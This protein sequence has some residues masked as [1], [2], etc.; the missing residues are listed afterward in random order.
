MRNILWAF[1]L[2]PLPAWA[3]DP[4]AIH[5]NVETSAL[6]VSECM[7]D[8]GGRS[9]R[10]QPFFKCRIENTT[11]NAISAAS[12]GV[13]I[14]EPER[15][16]QWM[17]EDEYPRHIGRREIQGGMEPGEVITVLL[18]VRQFPDRA[19]PSKVEITAHFTEAY[20]AD[21]ALIE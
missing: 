2:A 20:D 5:I 8:T 21:G 7:A 6:S 10:D 15:T 4:A 3:G 12:Y 17:P 18:A 13:T 1:L 11:A 14:Y 9:I 16:I 19:D